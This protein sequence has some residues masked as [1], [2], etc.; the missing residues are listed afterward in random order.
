M[1]VYDTV[2]K[3]T[4]ELDEKGLI[5]KMKEGRQVDIILKEKFT[6]EFGFMTWDQESWSTL[7]SKRFMRYCSLEGKPLS[8]FTTYNIYD[9]MDDFKPEEAAAVQ[10]S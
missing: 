2:N 4:L 10:L 3:E 8:E 6:D 9:M 7:D 5:Q 1:Q